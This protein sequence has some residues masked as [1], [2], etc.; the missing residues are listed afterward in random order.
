MKKWA[1]YNEID[2]KAA[3]WLRELMAAGEIMEGEVDERSI[4]EIKP[5]D[6]C[7]FVRC[8]WFAGIAGWDYALR[9]AGWPADRPIW[10]GSCP[11]QP[12]STAGKRQGQNDER[13]LWPEFY[14]L[15]KA[16]RPAIIFGEQVASAEVLG[17]HLEAAFVDAV[18]RGDCAKA[19]AI[20]RKLIATGT[21]HYWARW[22]DGVCFD[23]EASDY[24]CWANDLPAAGVGAP[25]RRQRLYWVANRVGAGLEGHAGDERDGDQSRR[26]GTDA[27]GPVTEGGATGGLLLS[28]VCAN[29]SSYTV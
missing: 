21:V 25:H 3:A 17:T 19:N 1:Y 18:S 2:P 14:R 16:C 8:H 22:F 24:T 29:V 6:V 10:T 23:L 13:H 9:L 15:I 27:T 4:T 11:C 12:F 26:I 20:A 7:G 5:E 28:T